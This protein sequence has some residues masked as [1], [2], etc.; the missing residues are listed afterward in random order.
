MLNTCSFKLQQLLV[1][2]QF[3]SLVA[4]PVGITSSAVGIKICA[5]MAG[6]KKCK[7]I[8]KKKKKHYKIVF[9]GNDKLYT[10]EVLISNFM[11]NLFQ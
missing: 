5:I 4:I 8:I 7:S 9:L 2:L 11:M 1:A 3:A 6:I 10:I